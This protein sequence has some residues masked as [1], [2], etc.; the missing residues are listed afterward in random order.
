VPVPTDVNVGLRTRALPGNA[1]ARTRG[2]TRRTLAQH[3]LAPVVAVPGPAS[4]RTD[5]AERISQSL[6]ARPGHGGT[7]RPATGLFGAFWAAMG[8]LDA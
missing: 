2:G 3:P 4:I 5:E 6:A 1:D 8:R 7:P